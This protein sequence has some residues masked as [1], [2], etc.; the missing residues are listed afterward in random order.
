MNAETEAVDFSKGDSLTVD[1]G[2]VEAAVFELVPKAIYPCLVA[3]CEFS[4]SQSG[5]NPMWT[6]TLEVAEGEYAGSKL[7]THLV[8]A[9]K[10][11]GYTK[12]TLERIK[13]ELLEAPFDSDDEEVMAG[14]L[15]LEVKAR[16][17]H[18]KWEGEMRANVA[19][20]YAGGGDDFV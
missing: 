7:F 6:L 19:G 14:M 2:G 9:G 20:L 15:G 17:T 10:G 5:G 11:L 4:Y 3:E 13:P 18:R 16:V 1:F 12:S 8:F